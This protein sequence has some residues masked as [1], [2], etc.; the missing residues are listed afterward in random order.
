MIR[1]KTSLNKF[2]KIEIVSSNFSD[3]TG[4]KRETNLKEKNPKTLKNKEIEEH[5]I[6]Q[7]MGEKLD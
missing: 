2:N 1:H 4:L 3:H 6:K 5:V 7:G